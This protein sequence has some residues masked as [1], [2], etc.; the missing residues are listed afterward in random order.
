MTTDRA[1]AKP[2]DV[3]VANISRDNDASTPQQNS[4]ASGNLPRNS[5]SAGNSLRGSQSK[6]SS[7][8]GRGRPYFQQRNNYRRSAE[9]SSGEHVPVT[10]GNSQQTSARNSSPSSSS[11]V[12]SSQHDSPLPQRNYH[13][14]NNA[15]DRPPSVSMTSLTTESSNA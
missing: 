10:S 2:D 6:R 12:V 4:P 5:L 11:V 14:Q 9:P 1:A 3:S 13:R 7:W 8:D 15:K